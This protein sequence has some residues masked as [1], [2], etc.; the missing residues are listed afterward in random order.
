[1]DSKQTMDYQEFDPEIGNIT[2][3]QNK[4]YQKMAEQLHFIS[5]C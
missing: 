3:E 5:L 4:S 2:E 1:M